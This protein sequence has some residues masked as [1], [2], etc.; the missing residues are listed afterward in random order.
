ME[1]MSWPEVDEDGFPQPPPDR[2]VRDGGS[3]ANWT[4]C[5]IGIVIIIAIIIL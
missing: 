4:L 5:G 2:L 1:E 3:E